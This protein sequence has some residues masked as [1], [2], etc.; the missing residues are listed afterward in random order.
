MLSDAQI[1]RLLDVANAACH[2]GN[3]ADARVIYE[4]VLALKP[5][6]APAL[7][8]KAL[9]HVVVD[10]FDE[11]ERILKEEVLSVRPDDPEGLA[12][13][14]LSSTTTPTLGNMIY[15]ARQYQAIM[16]KQWVWIGSPVLATSIMFIGLFLTYTG[17]NEYVA[18][19]RGR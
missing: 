18:K 8:G 9:S 4:G 5:A 7:V 15:W 13:L 3:V 19:K 2:T 17:Y 11:A 1:S 12:V 6:F 16:L 14:G 10:D